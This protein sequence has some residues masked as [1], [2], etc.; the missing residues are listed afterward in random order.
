[1]EFTLAPGTHSQP[2]ADL[3]NLMP[4]TTL[5]PANLFS[6]PGNRTR[7]LFPALAVLAISGKAEIR[8]EATL[9][10]ST[11]PYT[12]SLAAGINESGQ[13][14]GSAANANGLIQAA[15]WTDGQISILGGLYGLSSRGY[16]IND[17]GHV[18]GWSDVP[19]FTSQGQAFKWVDGV[20]T[21]LETLG[22]DFST[23]TGINNN[24]IVSGQAEDSSH[25]RR[26]VTWQGGSLSLLPLAEEGFETNAFGINAA[27]QVAGV[28]GQYLPCIGGGVSWGGQAVVWP[29]PLTLGSLG[30]GSMSQALAVNDL[31]QAAGW[32]DRSDS[33][34]GGGDS[35][36]GVGIAAVLFDNGAVV[37]LGDLGGFYS[38]ANALNNNGQV[39]GRASDGLDYRAFLWE[40]GV[41]T[42]LNDLVDPAQGLHL[43]SAVGINERGQIVCND[44][45]L[46]QAVLLTP[47]VNRPPVLVLPGVAAT[48]AADEND[49]GPW[50][51]TRGIHPDALRIDP[52]GHF[53]DD[54]LQTLDNAGY[55]PGED[56]FA[57][58]YDWRVTPA[59]VDGLFD[60]VISS[61]SAAAI[62]DGGFEHGVDYLGYWLMQA[63]DAWEAA[64]PG[65]TLREVDLIAHSTGGLVARAYLQSAARGGLL[66]DGRRLP[67]VRKLIM[68]G[69][70]NRGASKV[71]NPLHDDWGVDVSFQMVLSKMINLAFQKVLDGATVTGPDGDIDLQAL[72]ECDEDLKV[73]FLRKYVPTIHSL[74]ATFPFLD[75]GAGFQD[76]NANPALRNGLILDLN[77][78]LDLQLN[79]DP[80]SFADHAATTVIHATSEATP[81]LV[82]ERLGE[83]GGEDAL[84]SFDAF[85]PRDAQEGELWYEDLIPSQAGDGTV[86]LISSME[87]FVGD[88]RV[89]L[90]PYTRNV[91]TQEDVSHC[92]MLFNTQVQEEILTILGASFGPEDIST[93]LHAEFATTLS[94]ATN[95]AANIVGGNLLSLVLDP[96]EGFVVDG[97]GRRLGWSAATGAVAEIPGSFWTGDGDGLGW[98]FGPLVEPV[99]LQLTGQ[100]AEHY[101]QVGVA[102][103]WGQS[104]LVSTG[105]LAAGEPRSL[106]VPFPPLE[107]PA[108]EIVWNGPG[109][110]QLSWAPVAGATGYQVLAADTPEGP[111]ALLESTV[112]TSTTLSVGE[113]QTRLLR[114][115]AVR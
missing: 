25:F 68:V 70:P 111:W 43:S 107:A 96:V 51:F 77:A 2:I 74:L 55:T 56:L 99:T 114:V 94:T 106:S 71:W 52:L 5:R 80:N 81:R 84:V 79:G 110:A 93:N 73:C 92:G 112:A 72:L 85:L 26:A 4:R 53:Y 87:Q 101:A 50:L 7:L 36:D 45:W 59:P 18:A 97:Q 40:N 102:T 115:V 83:A 46:G 21:E 23:A 67:E 64:N 63:M 103:G 113:D 3:E 8:Y 39:V 57:A 14:V 49:I 98:Q 32:A 82:V 13:V 20:F 30:Y 12:Y 90:S 15:V 34:C 47:I 11:S 19:V 100:G 104:G 48:Y 58:N 6:P 33:Y 61:L 42:N 66:P 69:V 95:I 86:P 16:A 38:E 108:L 27:G 28:A 62:T 88:A 1:M 54:L 17:S 109:Q 60:G 37:D 76:V 41:M 65:D 75:T 35:R 89:T 29:G 10:P 9:L 31:G 78:G 24:G 22:G 91:N 44:A 105:P